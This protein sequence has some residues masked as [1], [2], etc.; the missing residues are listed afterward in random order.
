MSPN[1]YE[2]ETRKS[3]HILQ[4]KV[5]K[6]KEELER[7]VKL[8]QNYQGIKNKKEKVENYWI[9]TFFI[10]GVITLN[11]ILPY[12][13]GSKLFSTS[14]NPKIGPAD[15]IALLIGGAFLWKGLRK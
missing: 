13:I 15:I 11:F 3:L 12:F 14:F 10:I 8:F 4:E 6:T 9:G 1:D 5:N 2:K 7:E